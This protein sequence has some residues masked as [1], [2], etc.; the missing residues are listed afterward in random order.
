MGAGLT[1]ALGLSATTTACGSDAGDDQ[2]VL[3]LVA[4][5]YGDASDSGSTERYWNEVVAEFRTRHPQILVDVSVIR[6][7][8]ANAEVTRMVEA[9]DPPDIA[10]IS[11]FADFAENDRLHP[12]DEL[13]SLPVLADFVPSIAAAGKRLRVQY[14]MPFAASITRFFYNKDLFASAGLDPETPP[15]D[16]DELRQA[17]VALRTAGVGTPFGLPLADDNA[18]VEA[19]TWMLSGGGGLTDDFGSYTIDTP[20]N[21]ETFTWLRDAWVA[22]GLT[23]PDSPDRTTR[24][25]VYADFAAGEVGMVI[26]DTLLMRQA[27]VGGVSYGTATMPGVDGPT[28][29]AL[30]QASWV[31]AFNDSQRREEIG[32]FLDFVFTTKAVASFPER[33]E[34]LPVTTSEVDAMSESN[35]PDRQRLV[36]FL[37]ELPAATFY[38]VGK[39]SWAEVAVSFS[40]GIGETTRPDS[41]VGAILGRLQAEA[42]QADQRTS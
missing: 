3:R 26:A 16:W 29:T 10:Q 42:Q 15:R 5:E 39:V 20:A 40:Q 19:V 6:Y 36:P 34:F 30:G 14:A 28:S 22:D 9:G 31:M 32:T 18:H 4:A 35:D 17:A 41:D 13:L 8:D 25:T 38:P 23:G 2:V 37:D 7:D 24:E 33:Y 27:D 11:A 12:A 1:G 21:V